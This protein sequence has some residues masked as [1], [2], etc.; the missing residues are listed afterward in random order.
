MEHVEDN[1]PTLFA[2]FNEVKKV[3]DFGIR[4]RPEETLKQP[5]TM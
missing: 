5:A 2:E 3:K 4:H 1:Y